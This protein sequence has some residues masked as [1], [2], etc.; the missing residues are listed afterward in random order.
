[1]LPAKT[2][3]KQCLVPAAPALGFQDM[4]ASLRRLHAKE[5]I[6]QALAV[7]MSSFFHSP[8][9]CNYANLRRPATF[10]L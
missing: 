8:P 7:S 6:N 4:G 1:M 3:T 2:F 10:L 5:L 9:W